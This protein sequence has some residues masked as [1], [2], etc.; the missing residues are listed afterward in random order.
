MES[1]GLVHMEPLVA[2]KRI[3]AIGLLTQQ[4]VDLLGPTFDQLWAVEESPSFAGLLEAID[5]ADREL[6]RERD[7]PC[8]D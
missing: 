3:V 7:E 1:G 5:A 4:D 2:A 6:A 8:L